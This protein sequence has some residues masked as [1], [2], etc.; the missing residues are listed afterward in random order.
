MSSRQVEKGMA[1]VQPGLRN[2]LL[3][4]IHWLLFWLAVPA[5]QAEPVDAGHVEV[6]LIS[7][8]TA[9]APGQSF[10]VALRQQIDPH[11][12]TYWLN[13]GDSGQATSVAWQLPAGWSAGD[14]QFPLPKRIPY[15]P[16]M[17]FGYEGEVV[18][19]VLME[20]PET[21]DGTSV[22]LS[23]EVEWLVCEEICI[24]EE[25]SLYLELPVTSEAPPRDLRW[26]DV[27][28]R[29]GEQLPR[30]QVFDA[31]VSEQRDGEAV[32]AF[33]L[34]LQSSVL[35][36]SR[37]RD[38][39][40]FP[41]R[42][43]LI[44]NP[45]E[46]IFRLENDRLTL[47]LTPGFAAAFDPGAF[48][49]LVVVEAEAGALRTSAYEVQ[50]RLAG[51]QGMVDGGS[52]GLFAALV[53]AL[54]GGLILNLMPC[55]FPVLSI[56][57]LSLAGQVG[58]SPRLMRLHGLVYLAGVL[59]TFVAIGLLLLLLRLAGAQLGWGFQLQSP[60]V[61]TLLIYLLFLVGLS[62]SGFMIMGAGLMG[63]GGNWSTRTGLIGS[64]ATGILAV[65]VAAPC[66][67]PFMGPALGYAVTQPPVVAL[68]VFTFLGV[69]FALPYLL[70]SFAPGLLSL[71][72]RPGAWM[73]TLKE[74]F[75]FPMYG[76]AVW[77]LWVLSLQAGPNGVLLAGTGL[78]L[79][80]F[81]V[82][83][84]KSAEQAGLFWRNL[85]WG[86]ALLS[87]ASALALPAMVTSDAG[88]TA[89]GSQ[90]DAPAQGRSGQG[91]SWRQW[92]PDAVARAQEV[93]P[94]FVNFTAAWCI[95]C[96]VN[97][98]VALSSAKIA[99]A[100]AEQGVIYLKGD[101]TLEDPAITAAL[102]E[103]GR[104]GVPLYLIY[105]PAGSD[106]EVQ[107]LPQVLTQAIVINALKSADERL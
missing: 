92:S 40:Y 39:S 4:V 91:P 88:T 97:E 44:S 7:E 72:P 64:F 58:E 1:P 56:K 35:A 63:I 107:I 26:V 99:E 15:G 2:L 68:V 22:K 76:A 12:H 34:E 106:K 41:Y 93:G 8:V 29:A 71:L 3:P 104:N 10:R 60:L 38:V 53:G 62:L 31:E 46:Q 13:P 33:V 95:T 23:A 37:I 19:P 24:P 42:E 83:L 70:L 89:A 49:G 87:L 90:P 65:F 36:G 59:V 21:L 27:F 74:F 67:A 55:V 11:W 96:K 103:Y 69:G 79:L 84:L 20:V 101:W 30:Q 73:E 25:A 75:A 81:A 32:S 78:V 16:L 94:V 50:P 28:R 52:Y 77:L 6:E 43:G 61:V 82:W 5:L 57:L 100:F 85:L 47:E 54:L 98:S 17:N 51:S 14:L 102:A 45:A 66:T 105:P 48:D 86:M 18:Y 80:T 9:V